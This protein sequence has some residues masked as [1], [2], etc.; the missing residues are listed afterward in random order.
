MRRTAGLLAV[1]ALAVAAP[2]AAAA[3]PA[4]EAFM[5]NGEPTT[6]VHAEGNSATIGD[7]RYVVA[8]FSFTPTGGATEVKTAGKKTGLSNP[9]TCTTEVPG[10]TFGVVLLPV[11][12]G[13]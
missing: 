12:P 5:C 13:R 8:S 9:L 6:V 10:G 3:P 11:P 7:Q 1:S 4:G 2:S